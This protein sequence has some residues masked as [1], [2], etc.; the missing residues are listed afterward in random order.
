MIDGCVSWCIF[1]LLLKLGQ[2]RLFLQGNH[3]EH[4]GRVGTSHPAAPDSILGV[5]N[6]FSEFLMLL[7]LIDGTS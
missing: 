7:R 1:G 2:S 5:P 6:T 3:S 4:R